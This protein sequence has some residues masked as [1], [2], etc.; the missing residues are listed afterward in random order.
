MSR[1]KNPGHSR[2]GWRLTLIEV[3]YRLRRWGVLELLES[4]QESDDSSAF[5]LTVSKGR[6][7][8]RFVT[9]H[10]ISVA[11]YHVNFLT[12][13]YRA[14][15]AK[16]TAKIIREIVYREKGIERNGSNGIDEV[17]RAYRRY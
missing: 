17:G 10:R 8:S 15:T 3:E 5:V 13:H 7:F 9:V 16:E 2:S 11:N 14:R 12:E 6:F 1:A 4:I